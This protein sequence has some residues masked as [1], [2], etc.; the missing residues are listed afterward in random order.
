MRDALLYL[1]PSLVFALLEQFALFYSFFY[2]GALLIGRDRHRRAWKVAVK[3]DGV[4]RSLQMPDTA[5]RRDS[6]QRGQPLL[7]FFGALVI[8]MIISLL[9]RASRFR[10][11]RPDG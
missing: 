7:Q 1:S 5:S 9:D 6:R 4:H 2:A 3:P 8:V 11:Q 10:R